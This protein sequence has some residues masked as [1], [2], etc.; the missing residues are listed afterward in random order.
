M[1]CNSVATIII[2]VSVLSIVTSQWM[3]QR[4]ALIFS[5]LLRHMV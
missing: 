2:N 4:S 5:F 3:Q 1:L